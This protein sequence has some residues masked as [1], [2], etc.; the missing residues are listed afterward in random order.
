[1]IGPFKTGQQFIA[2]EI[3]AQ[4][5]IEKIIDDSIAATPRRRTRLQPKPDKPR[6]QMHQSYESR[7][8]SGHRRAYTR[9]VGSE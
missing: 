6:R 5:P 8:S 7:G 2:A 9:M 1:M 4:P 3:P